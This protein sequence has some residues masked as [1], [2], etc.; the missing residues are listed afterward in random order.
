MFPTILAFQFM[1]IKQSMPS[2]VPSL[3]NISPLQGGATHLV[4]LGNSDLMVSRVGLGCWPMAGITSTGVSDEES[5]ATVKAALDHG[6]NFFDTAYA[7]GF[8]GRSDRVLRIGLGDRRKNVVIAH[9]VGTHWNEKKERCIDG[10]PVRLIAQ[11]EECLMR[12]NTD[13][14][15]LM[16]LHT[17]DPH[18]PIQESAGAIKELLDRGWV[19]F[20]AVSNVTSEQAANFEAVCPVVA[21]Q[22]YFNMF[23]RDAVESLAP[24][25]QSHNVAIVCYWVLMKGLLAGKLK[26]DHVFDPADRRLT[27]PVFQGQAWHRAQDLLDRLRAMSL[28]LG[29]T[30][31][32]LVIA[33][34]LQQPGISV[35]LLGAKRPDQ[36]AETSH[37]MHIKLEQHAIQTINHWIRQANASDPQDRR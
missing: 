30:V 15:D 37:A 19:R 22:P 28:E 9:K 25:T 36:I 26:R 2:M 32:Q 35:A 11:A 14:I 1:R 23:Q 12:L 33:W 20:A 29:I 4:Q 10:S 8:D 27:Y 17:P 24:F 21:I 5:I 3:N 13:F 6:I 31:S 16:Y 34:T 7:Y 18:V